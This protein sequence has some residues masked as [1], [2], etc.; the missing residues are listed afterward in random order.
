[1]AVNPAKNLL[2]FNGKDFSKYKIRIFDLGSGEMFINNIALT[3]EINIS[4]L[5]AGVYG[6]NIYDNAGYEQNG[7]VIIK[8]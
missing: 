5:K 1:M 4:K 2:I 3:E 7:K 6:Y 8:D